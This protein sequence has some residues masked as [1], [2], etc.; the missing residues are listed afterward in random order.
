MDS[1]AHDTRTVLMV[2]NPNVG[3]SALF[4]RL[5][6]AEAVVS[7]YPGTTVDVTRGHFVDGGTR[8]EV[9]DVPGA[10]SLDTRD[11]AEE[12]AVRLLDAHPGAVVLLVLDATRLERGLYLGFEVMERGAPVLVVLNMMDA[13]R[14]KAITV[15]DRRLQV[16]LGVPV[17]CT[18]AVLGE[19]I[20]HLADML[21]KAR[22]A[23]IGLVSARANGTATEPPRPVG[24]IGCG[25]CR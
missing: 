4:N 12:V 17:V 6:G 9:I 21:R 25:G 22:P 2:G 3:K 7:N 11:A 8:Y 23:D 16:I 14:E 20:R 24:C 5:T 1:G 13:A 10:Y 19:G 15:D 18:S